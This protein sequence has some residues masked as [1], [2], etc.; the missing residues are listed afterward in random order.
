MTTTQIIAKQGWAGALILLVIFV[1]CMWFEWDTCAFIS[2]VLLALWL[3]MFR[4]PERIPQNDENNVFVS[5]VDGI[6]REISSD[7]NN[8][9]ILIET[10]F[11]DVGV[12]R[13]PCDIVEG[14]CDEKKGLS[15]SFCSKDKRKQLNATMLFQSIQDRAFFMEFYPV[16]FSSQHIFATSRL[17]IGER[18]GFMKMGMTRIIFPISSKKGV[19]SESIELKIN[20]GD[21]VR[22]SQSVIGYFYEV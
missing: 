6:V 20:I 10:S 21:R 2:F 12:V 1:L 8:I 11:L 17:D 15:L 3:A 4:N 7:E 5:P 16:F 19:D 14:K 9:H 22:A 13:A 18:M